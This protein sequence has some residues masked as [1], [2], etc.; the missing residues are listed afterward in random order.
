[1]D[2][3]DISQLEE[4]RRQREEYLGLLVLALSKNPLKLERFRVLGGNLGLDEL[5]AIPHRVRILV[6]VLNGEWPVGFTESKA[7]PDTQERISFLIDSLHKILELFRTPEVES[8]VERTATTEIELLETQLNQFLLEYQ[9]SPEIRFRNASLGFHVEECQTRFD[10]VD[11]ETRFLVFQHEPGPV[12]ELFCVRTVIDLVKENQVDRVRRCES[13][14]KWFYAEKCDKALCGA[15][16]RQAKYAIAKKSFK[17]D[18]ALYMRWRYALS[19]SKA[20]MEIPERKRPTWG[21]WKRF[22][23]RHGNVPTPDEWSAV[24]RRGQR[25]AKK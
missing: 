4:Q 6:G 3:A 2:Y 12:I 17:A 19:E 24:L 21:E 18:R 11:D 16:C 1:M 22:Q 7:R 13:C 15:K 20:W 9:T 14:R 8:T 10:V 5:P 25:I 23:E